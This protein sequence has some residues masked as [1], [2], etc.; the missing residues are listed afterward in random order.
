MT[1]K[2]QFAIKDARNFAK[3]NLNTKEISNSHSKDF[4]RELCNVIAG[5]LKHTL[6]ENNIQVGISLPLLARGFDDLFLT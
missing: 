3:S 1:F 4:I 6:S 2:I 5:Y